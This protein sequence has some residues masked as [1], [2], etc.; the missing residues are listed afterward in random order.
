MS[1]CPKLHLCACVSPPARMFRV[2]LVAVLM[3]LARHE[4]ER[5]DKN[6]RRWTQPSPLRSYQLSLLTSP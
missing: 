5:S 1:S 4:G 3:V 2:G 6:G